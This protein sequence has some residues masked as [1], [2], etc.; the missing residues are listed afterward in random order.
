MTGQER[1]RYERVETH[2]KVKLPEDVAWTECACCSV[3]GGGLCFDSARQQK[4]GAIVSLQVMLS[5]KDRNDGQCPFLG[6]CQSY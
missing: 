3:S 6:F 2:V 5:D 1:R 4:V